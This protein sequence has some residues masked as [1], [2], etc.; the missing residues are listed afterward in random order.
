[1][2]KVLSVL[3]LFL[4]SVDISASAATS[5]PFG[6]KPTSPPLTLSGPGVKIIGKYFPTGGIICN[7]C[8]G[9]IIDQNDFGPGAGFTCNFCS[10]TIEMSNNRFKLIGQYGILI[11]NST[12][13]GTIA[14]N[15][16]RG[17]SSNAVNFIADINSGGIDDA[18]RLTFSYNHWDGRDP[19]TTDANGNVV[20]GLA[21]YGPTNDAAYY[22]GG[23]TDTTKGFIYWIYNTC[24]DPAP[25][26][27]HVGGGHDVVLYYNIMMGE[28]L[29]GSIAAISVRKDPPPFVGGDVAL[30]VGDTKWQNAAGG[31]ALYDN[32]DNDPSLVITYLSNVGLAINLDTYPNFVNFP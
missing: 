16:A 28:K 17:R 5:I 8:S 6:S 2:R 32:V 7:N 22:T 27:L 12:L 29:P 31:E 9:A 23:M 26:C 18:N 19:D 30:D 13:H 21:V 11:K 24:W 14:H 25:Y 3:A 4:A 1:M 20:H 10:G 15:A